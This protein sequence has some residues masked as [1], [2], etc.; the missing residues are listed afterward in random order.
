MKNTSLSL[1]CW[2]VN[3]GHPSAYHPFFTD[4]TTFNQSG[5]GPAQTDTLAP[6]TP[7]VELTEQGRLECSLKPFS[8]LGAGQQ[9]DAGPTTAKAG[10]RAVLAAL[11]SGRHGPGNMRSYLEGT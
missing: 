3:P 5:A 1:L 4:V 11:R 9:G 7:A 6:Q 10:T 8:G 2:T